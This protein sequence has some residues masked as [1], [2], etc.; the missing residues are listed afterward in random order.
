MNKKNK[1]I[2]T[3]LILAVIAFLLGCGGYTIAMNPPGLEDRFADLFPA[4]IDGDLARTRA[5]VQLGGIEAFY[6]PSEE[7]FKSED[8]D[9]D[10]FNKY[11][12]IFFHEE[13]EKVQQTFL[14]QIYPEFQ[15]LPSFSLLDEQ[16][17]YLAIGTREDGQEWVAWTNHFYLFALKGRDKDQINSLVDSF[18]YISR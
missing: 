13:Q 1:R 18:P 15:R 6:G 16:G 9:P 12:F 8:F 11:L 7:E 5:L 2:Q 3:P 10:D 4:M 14:D 17:E